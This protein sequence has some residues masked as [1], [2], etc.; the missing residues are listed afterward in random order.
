MQAVGPQSSA[1]FAV[2]RGVSMPLQLNYQR[3]RWRQL[4]VSIQLWISIVFSARTGIFILCTW[5]QTWMEWFL[6]SQMKR[7]SC[8]LRNHG[9]SWDF[10]E[11]C[12]E[13]QR[14]VKWSSV[15]LILESG[16]NL[17][18]SMM[19][20]LVLLQVD[21]RASAN[22]HQTSLATSKQ[23]H[24]NYQQCKEGLLA[25]TRKANMKSIYIQY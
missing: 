16:R 4:L 18:V 1:W 12:T 3:K 2:T 21:G 17:K 15:C 11:M 9:T 19:M 24:D 10:Q 25:P 5:W 20:G 23:L 7:C 22:P 14:R 13:H 6:F 8:T